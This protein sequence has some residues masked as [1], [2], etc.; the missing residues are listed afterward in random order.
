MFTE[1]FPI[2]SPEGSSPA[3]GFFLG[4]DDSTRALRDALEA[5][6]GVL[7]GYLRGGLLWF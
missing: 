4:I 3:K 1:N 2:G 5:L 6:L 7:K